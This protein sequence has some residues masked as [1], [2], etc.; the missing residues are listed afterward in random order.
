MPKTNEMKVLLVEQKVLSAS[1]S[2]P[3]LSFNTL[4]GTNSYKA[5]VEMCI[6]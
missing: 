1:I 3:S 5:E 4:Y 2:Q 6:K